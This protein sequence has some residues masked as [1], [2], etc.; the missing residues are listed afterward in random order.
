MLGAVAWLQWRQSQLVSQ[1]LLSGGDNKAHFLYQADNEY[2]RLR[3]S[4]PRPEVRAT[5]D[6]AALQLRYDIFVSRVGVLRDAGRAPGMTLQPEI[7][8]ALGEAESFI[9]R[10]DRLLGPGAS[11]LNASELAVLYPDLLKL[12][13]Q[14]RA[15]TQSASDLVAGSATRL[16]EA[17]R[18]QNRFGLMMTLLLA[19]LAA[20]FAVLTLRE[21]RREQNK[22][23]ELEE[24]TI[25]LRNAQRAAEA[26]AAAKSAFLANMSHEIRTPFQGL[27]GM[28]GLLGKT[29]LDQTQAG[30]LRT[31][32]G[33]ASHLLTILN[34]V[35]D[36]SSLD[37]GSIKIVP[38]PV[39]LVDLLSEVQAL[40]QP[41]ASTKGLQLR[42]VALPGLPQ[43]ALLDPTR[44]R[45][46]LFNLLSNAIKFTDVGWVT[47]EAG[48]AHQG[49]ENSA[50]KALR[51]VV[52]DTGVGMD[53]AGMSR[54]FE[55]FAQAD[56][57][58]SRR[59]GG[60]GLGLEISRRLV[61][62]MGGDIT[63]TSRLGEGSTFVVSVPWVEPLEEAT[64][65]GP[66]RPAV[67]A[68]EHAQGHSQAAGGP[69]PGH[70]PA[71]QKGSAEH[72]TGRRMSI[73]VAEDNEVNRLVMEAILE[74]LGH[75]VHFAVDGVQAVEMAARR[76]WDAVLMDLHMPNMDG[77]D[78]MRA[79]RAGTDP[80]KAAV[81]VVALT[82]DVFET[83]R[84]R[85]EAEGISDFLTKPVSVA[86]LKECLD[87]L[88]AARA[89][90]VQA[91]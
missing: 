55:R 64:E 13:A 88:G 77:F 37:S 83:T 82:A 7:A 90:T 24:L 14:M 2:L 31:A 87:R 44:M 18:A 52:S 21:L 26:A 20:G 60:A 84:Q 78:A 69:A 68:T 47:L 33:S 23:Q 3:E 43:R 39:D 28:L 66:D 25:D 8:R 59:F 49:D 45:Q 53:A 76:Q 91:A 85:C 80:V 35:L 29:R 57:S 42:V 15:L 54:L 67:S 38:A 75:E 89:P 48:L 30:Y 79:I 63:A 34:D 5:G 22:R 6:L 36:A 56:N 46:V 65:R 70:D 4:W 72:E 41:Q 19:L 40:M 86:E 50:V 58:R 27:Q 74:E 11:A 73:L 12:D 17:G 62:L 71:G 10:A 9:A 61:R 16:T 32:A 1:A 81:R 51:F